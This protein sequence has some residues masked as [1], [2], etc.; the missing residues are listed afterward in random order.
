[1]VK[2]KL[3]DGPTTPALWQIVQWITRPFAFMEACARD[4]GDIFTVSIGQVPGS[5]V[6]VSNPQAMQEILST[7]SKK[8]DAP[9]EVNK[10]F[11]LLL[12]DYSVITLSGTRHRRERH[13]LV[14]PFHG[15]RMQGYGQLSR[16]RS[17]G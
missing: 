7:D 3:P 16:T 8:F 13:L 11:S 15:E 4:Y 10:I 1:M 9:G 2:T 6:F 14:P 12:G 17:F 5:T